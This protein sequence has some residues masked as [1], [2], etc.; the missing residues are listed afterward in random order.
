MS[1]STLG[2]VIQRAISDAAFRGQLQTNPAAALRGF[3]LTADETAALRS[4]DPAR[5]SALGI[6]QRISKAF[7]FSGNFSGVSS[8]N[9]ASD[10]SANS[11]ADLS[12]DSAADMSAN[13]AADLSGNSALIDPGVAG[14]DALIA[15][16]TDTAATID[17]GAGVAGGAYITADE[18]GHDYIPS[19]ASGVSDTPGGSAYVTADEAGHD[20]LGS[21]HGDGSALAPQIGGTPV[22]THISSGDFDS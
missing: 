9:S 6:D 16:S 12:A 7:S 4:G 5:L 14:G 22:D 17:G 20:S 2:T 8:A 21:G 3:D 1:S 18:A 15:G 10:L 13:S 19:G 11:S